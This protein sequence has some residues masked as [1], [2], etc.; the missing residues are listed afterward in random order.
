MTCKLLIRVVSTYFEFDLPGRNKGRFNEYLLCS[1]AIEHLHI[2]IG[3]KYDNYWNKFQKSQFLA[4][5]H[6]WLKQGMFF[7]VAQCID[8]LI[9]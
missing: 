3:L 8:Y 7:F 6:P 4:L 5:G 2:H 1:M 9:L